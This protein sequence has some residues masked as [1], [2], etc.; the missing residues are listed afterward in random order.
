MMGRRVQQEEEEVNDGSQGLAE[1]NDGSQG[2]AVYSLS[3]GCLFALYSLSN[4]CITVILCSNDWERETMAQQCD[5]IIATRITT[6]AELQ[7]ARTR[8]N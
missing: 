4:G 2:S 7:Q 1:G 6:P 8:A 5:C 3:I